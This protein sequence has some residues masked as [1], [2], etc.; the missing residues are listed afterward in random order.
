MV[1][2]I[3]SAVVGLAGDF[4]ISSMIRSGSPE[5]TGSSQVKKEVINASAHNSVKPINKFPFFIT[6]YSLM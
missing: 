4:V 5:L 1:K 2:V 6:L 3:E